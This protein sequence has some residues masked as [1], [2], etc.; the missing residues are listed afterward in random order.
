MSGNVSL[1]MIGTAALS[2]LTTRHFKAGG[3]IARLLFGK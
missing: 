2:P 1:V 3:A